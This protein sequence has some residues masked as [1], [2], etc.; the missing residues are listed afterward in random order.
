M[1][2]GAMVVWAAP[3]GAAAAWAMPALYRYGGGWG[4]YGGGWL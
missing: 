1:A 3:V 4:G 2:V